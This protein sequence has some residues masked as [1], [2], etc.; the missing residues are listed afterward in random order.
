VDSLDAYAE[1]ARSAV[2]GARGDGL[3]AVSMFGGVM[4]LP[5]LM[6]LAVTA[7]GS[8]LVAY[9]AIGGRT[10]SGIAG[11]PA[12]ETFTIKM[13]MHVRPKV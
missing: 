5:A 3:G 7:S 10:L 13:E 9:S 4:V 1:Y 12:S 2:S 11:V 8:Y 6:S